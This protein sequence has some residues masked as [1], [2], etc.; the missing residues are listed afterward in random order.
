MTYIGI[1][2]SIGFTGVTVKRYD[3]IRFYGITYKKHTKWDKCPQKFN[4]TILDYNRLEKSDDYV[5]NERIKYWN[6]KSIVNT[7]SKIFDE[8]IDDEVEVRMEGVSYGSKQTSAIVELAGLNFLIRDLCIA[9]GWKFTVLPPT[10]IKKFA[11]GNGQAD[12]DLMLA[13]FLTINDYLKP[14]NKIIKLD[15]IAD[16]YFMASFE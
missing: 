4:I 12:K 6:I 15:D 16:S 11:T 8:V 1:D 14:I 7:I 13:S 5:E 2:Q 9:K 10:V 3:D